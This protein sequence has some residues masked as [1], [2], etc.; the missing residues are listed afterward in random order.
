MPACSH[1]GKTRCRALTVL[2][3]VAVDDVGVDPFTHGVV[4]A[5]LHLVV[6]EGVE[7]MQFCRW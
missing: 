5:D 3:R 7:V 4:G 2:Q 1:V 6:A